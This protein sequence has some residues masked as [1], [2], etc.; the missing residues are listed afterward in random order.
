MHVHPLATF[1]WFYYGLLGLLEIGYGLGGPVS[2]R[3]GMRTTSPQR[4]AH[5]VIACSWL[6]S[7]LAQA[8]LPKYYISD[9]YVGGVVGVF[10]AQTLLCIALP[11]LWRSLGNEAALFGITGMPNRRY[12]VWG[13]IAWIALVAL[14]AIIGCA[15]LV[16]QPQFGA[17]ISIWIAWTLV[18]T[19]V[20]SLTV[21][22]GIWRYWLTWQAIHEL[23]LAWHEGSNGT[24]S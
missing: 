21:T 22:V 9:V 24:K 13:V 11:V 19:A 14:L 20:I 3:S 6:A 18:I 8:L 17:V 12:A 4:A 16:L 5:Y 2:I 15:G 7:G 23:T 10:V 1:D